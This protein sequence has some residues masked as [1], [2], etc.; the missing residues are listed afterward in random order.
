[1]KKVKFKGKEYDLEEKDRIFAEILI[2]ISKKLGV[3]ANG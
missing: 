2:E 1:M 3:L